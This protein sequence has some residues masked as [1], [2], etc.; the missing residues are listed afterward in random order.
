MSAQTRKPYLVVWGLLA[1]LTSLEIA[2]ANPSL[3]IPRVLVGTA[4]VA[5]AVMKAAFVAY[6]FMH[7]RHEMRALKL[8][9][10]L[11]FLAPAL[12]AF[13]LVA[14]ATWRLLR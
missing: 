4:L 8:T 11:P 13:V 1:L 3:E 5:M 10:T 7:L 2:V 9:V 12:Y 6:Y 14:E